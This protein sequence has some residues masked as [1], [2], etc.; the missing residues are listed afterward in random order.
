LPQPKCSDDNVTIF[1][2]FVV[3]SE[4]FN[5]LMTTDLMNI[6]FFI[7][8]TIPVGVR[9]AQGLGLRLMLSI[10]S[11]TNV[12]CHGSGLERSHEQVTALVR[13][14]MCCYLT[15]KLF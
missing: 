9:L 7:T 6:I 13:N 1:H 2:Y 10:T 12:Y 11:G 8:K 3:I 14:C 4:L 5:E 15:T